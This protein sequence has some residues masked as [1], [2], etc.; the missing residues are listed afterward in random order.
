MSLGL[1]LR[2]W[3]LPSLSSLLPLVRVSLF[4]VSSIPP[5]SSLFA[6]QHQQRLVV[7][8][9]E[10][11][12]DHVERERKRYDRLVHRLVHRLVDDVIDVQHRLVIVGLLG[13]DLGHHRVVVW[14]LGQDIRI[15]CHR[16]IVERLYALQRGER[17]SQVVMS[18]ADQPG[19]TGDVVLR[20]RAMGRWQKGG[21]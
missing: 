19:S 18:F 14:L 4:L 1:R 13:Q 11:I 10:R 16:L 8:R 12:D 2:L 9:N 6:N 5:F 20:L 3:G 15:R 21:E 17:G 7:L